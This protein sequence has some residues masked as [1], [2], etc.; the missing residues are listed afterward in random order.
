MVPLGKLQLQLKSSFPGTTYQA[1]KPTRTAILG[2]P[3]VHVSAVESCCFLPGFGS[4]NSAIMRRIEREFLPRKFRTPN[5]IIG[6][7]QTSI[8]GSNEVSF[9]PPP[10]GYPSETSTISI[11]PAIASRNLAVCGIGPRGASA[12]GEHFWH[13]STRNKDARE[14]GDAG[15]AVGR[16]RY[17]GQAYLPTVAAEAFLPSLQSC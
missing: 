6:D 4:E 3:Q 11:F 14:E 15:T 13:D 16:T 7:R 9:L 1:N 17:V 8:M 12:R 2:K 10:P 5:S